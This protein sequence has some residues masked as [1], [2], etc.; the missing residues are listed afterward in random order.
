MLTICGKDL[1]SG[2]ISLHQARCFKCGG[3]P[4]HPPGTLHPVD[5]FTPDEAMSIV[6]HTTD[7]KY[8]Y[9]FY[10]LYETGAR[11]GEG[12]AVTKTDLKVESCEVGF[13][14][15]KAKPKAYRQIPVSSMLMAELF[16][17]SRY[18][19]GKHLFAVSYSSVI[20]NLR[21]SALRAGIT[22]RVCSHM[23]R[24]GMIRNIITD[25]SGSPTNALSY[26]AKIAGHKKIETTMIYAN[27]TEREAKDAYRKLLERM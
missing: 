14:T 8:Y 3:N 22:R 15:E 6:L 18:I 21:Q 20:Y 25:Y 26:A 19:R 1:P 9:L 4:P 17:Y 5:Y 23:F 27:S 7:D 2:K 10:L 16:Q 11:I 24:H 12:L 13:W